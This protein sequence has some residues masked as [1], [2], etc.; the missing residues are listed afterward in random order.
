MSLFVS[1]PLTSLLFSTAEGHATPSLFTR[2]FLRFFTS[3]YNQTYLGLALYLFLALALCGLLAIL[4]YLL[5]LS[6]SQDTEKRSEYECGFAPFDS[7]TRLPFDVHF[8]LVGILFLIFDVEIAL[9]F[10]WVLSLHTIGWFGFYL[11]IS[12]ILVLSVGFLYEWK[13]GALIWPA[14]YSALRTDLSASKWTL[15][16][17]LGGSHTDTLPAAFKQIAGVANYG[18]ELVGPLLPECT[19]F[20]MIT[21]ILTL[22]A[23]ELGAG[24]AKKALALEIWNASR[25]GFLLVAVLYLCQLGGNALETTILAGHFFTSKG[26]IAFKL[27]VLLS[28]LFVLDS[29]ERYI[30][31]HRRHLLEYSILLSLSIL[32][33][34]LLVGANHLIAAFLAVV[35]FSLNLYVLVLSDLSSHPSRE[36]GLKY[37]YL[38]TVS[39]GFIIYG[40]FLLYAMTGTAEFGK[41]GEVFSTATI[42]HHNLLLV[43]VHLILLGFFFKLSAVPGHLWA[44]EVYEGS[45]SP[46]TAF[47][48]LP[49]KA[50]VLVFLIRF[51]ATALAPLADYWL[52]FV[53][54]AA[55]ASLLWGAFAASYERKTKR[56]LGYAA[57]NQMGFLLMG[58][59][60]DTDVAIRATSLYLFLYLLMSAGFLM[61]FL[62]ARRAD[63]FELIYLSDFRGLAKKEWLLS[64]SFA[65]I[66]FSMAGIPPLAGFF[67]KYYILAHAIEKGLLYLAALGLLTSLIS[68][69]YYISIVRTMWFEQT[70]KV[71][72]VKCELTRS[73]RLGLLFIELT[74]WLGA[75]FAPALLSLL[76][77]LPSALLALYLTASSSSLF[78][79]S[80]TPLATPSHQRCPFPPPP[81]NACVL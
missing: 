10:P 18:A 50:A 41:L 66:L 26:I 57:I 1:P 21:Y 68:A 27:V 22:A 78:F 52:P 33:L 7:A 12:F 32:F 25:V 30:R 2:S 8:Y 34:L 46:I 69:Y 76:D 47:F 75:F 9:L 44:V 37:Y 42:L 23:Y 64:W 60:C 16:P 19:L 14:R 35:G 39:S 49:V 79:L 61:V 58:L 38:S 4:A 29:S 43:S 28:G 70:D 53:T 63:N 51:L 65:I 15:L 3:Q 6:T 73:Q 48:M 45:P 72:D 11:M 31:E 77:L 74:L 36:A 62:H 24:R 40:V 17:M 56:F 81:P 13:R 67:G 20:V 54:F 59:C 80:I 71:V 5:A 55:A